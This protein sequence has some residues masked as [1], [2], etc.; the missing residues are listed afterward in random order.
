MPKLRQSYWQQ[1]DLLYKKSSKKQLF[2]RLLEQVKLLG[3]PIV[4]TDPRGRKP[5]FSPLEYVSFVCFE[6]IFGHKYREMELDSD[7]F[8]CDKADHSTFQ[9]WYERIPQE[10]L[11]RLTVS[12][13]NREFSIWIADSTAM[14]SK[15]NVERLRA[16]TRN[17][18]KLTDKYHIIIG[19][20]PPTSTTMILGVVASDNKLSDSQGAIKILQEKNNEYGWFLGD[21]AYNTYELHELIEKIGLYAQMKPDKKGIKRKL[22]AKAKQTKFFCKP[23]YKQTRGVVET[24]FG[25]STNAG[26]ILS[27]AKK[28]HTRRLDTLILAIRHNFF[29]AMRSTT[30]IILRQ[31]LK[32]RNIFIPQTNRYAYRGE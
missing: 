10:Y 29:A 1:Y 27:Y 2:K 31:T 16:G 25:G 8:L 32:H 26:L 5:K 6:K 24:V 18:T 13:V 7:L 14:S 15:I 4:K 3:D 23:L 12:F 20:D 28:K 19:Y 22:S 9:R 21:S 11:E 17:K 30:L